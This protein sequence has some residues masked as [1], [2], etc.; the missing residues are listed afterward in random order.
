MQAWIDEQM[1]HF[2]QGSM[3]PAVQMLLAF[4]RS[5]CNKAAAQKGAAA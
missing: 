5:D 3:A 2:P 1:K 4:E